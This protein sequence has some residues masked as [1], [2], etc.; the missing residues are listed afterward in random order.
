MESTKSRLIAHAATLFAKNGCKSIT[1]DDI[2]NSMGIS[3]RTI[4]EKFTDKEALLE[5]CLHYFF[6]HRELDVKQ[7]LESSDNIIA[8]IFK[9]LDNTS[10]IF[11][12][13]QFNFFNDIQKYYPETYNNTVKVYKQ[14]Y[15]T[16]TEK[17]LQK[18]IIDGIV[19]K[20]INPALMAIFI[21]ETSVLI[22]HRDV[23]ADYGY[24]KKSAMQACMSCI[25]RGMFT[26]KG[27]QIL[28]EHIDEFRRTK[29]PVGR[30]Y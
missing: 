17:L 30:Y 23:F 18:G 19:R 20:E 1:M 15:I 26:D 14:Q 25:T 11:F 10:K 7:I 22:L 6:E 21:S 3:K 8:A 12:Q 27:V 29:T 4:Y 16:N 5:A 2:A 9:L 13:L 24:E 28:D